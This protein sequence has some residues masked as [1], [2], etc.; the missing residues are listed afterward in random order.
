MEIVITAVI[1]LLLGGVIVFLVKRM[2][3]QTTKKSA[4]MEAERILNRAK[5]ESTKIKK[6]SETKAKDFESRARK[7]VE[8]DIHKQKSTLKNKEA[9]LERRLKEID[10]QLKAKTEETDRYLNTL[11][12]REEKIGISES[13]VKDLEKKGEEQIGALKQKLETVAAINK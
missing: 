4:R 3:D 7:N 11:K 6:D 5:S 13:R 8:A 2:Q 12:D 1:A 10:D 9:Q